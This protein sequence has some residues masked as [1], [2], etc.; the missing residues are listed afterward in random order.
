MDAYGHVKIESLRANRVK[1]AQIY[2]FYTLDSSRIEFRV[3]A[4][5]RLGESEERLSESSRESPIF[6]LLSDAEW[7][8]MSSRVDSV[9]WRED[10]VME[11][12]DELF[13]QLGESKAIFLAQEQLVELFI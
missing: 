10:L 1:G 3:A 11:G 9:S 7:G 6:P 13:I 4:C 8:P 12:L 2:K 5:M